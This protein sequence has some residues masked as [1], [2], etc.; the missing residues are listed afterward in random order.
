MGLVD[1]VVAPAVLLDAAIALARTGQRPF[2]QRATAW[3]SNTWLARKLLAPQMLKQVARKAKKDQYPAPF[4]LI[5]LAERRRQGHPGR[6]DA[7]RR[8]GQAGRFRR[9]RAT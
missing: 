7:E 1:K 5:D 9:P 6:L 4:A 8:G 2:K 3:A